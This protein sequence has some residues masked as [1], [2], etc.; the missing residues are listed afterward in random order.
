MEAYPSVVCALY[1]GGLDASSSGDDCGV[2]VPS[3]HLNGT[4]GGHGDIGVVCVP[5][6]L[7]LD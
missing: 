3:V 5:S 4:G 2:Y 7:S 6:A 1:C